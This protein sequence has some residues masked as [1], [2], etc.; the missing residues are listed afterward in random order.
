MRKRR[1][2]ELAKTPADTILLL[3]GM[4]VMSDF[5][6]E[7]EA[8]LLDAFLKTLPEFRLED[9]DELKATVAKLRAEYASPR[10]SIAALGRISSDI[11]KKKTFILALDIAMASGAIDA[12]ED[13]LL[14]D[15]RNVL[16]LDLATAET[17][18]DVLSVKYAS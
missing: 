16:G 8:A 10:E 12:T 5:R 14:E 3:H 1:T 4:M 7:A 15:L 9:I 2:Y 13:D 11:V 6:T 18:L 17:I